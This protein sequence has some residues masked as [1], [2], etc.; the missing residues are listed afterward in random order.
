MHFSWSKTP[1]P[2]HSECFVAVLLTRNRAEFWTFFALPNFREPAIQKL[3]PFFT[4]VV[5]MFLCMFFK[6]F[7]IKVKKYVFY[8]FYSKIIVFVIYALKDVY[9]SS[10][11]H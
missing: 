2:G 8:V 6:C 1:F 4:P 11:W 5:L 3:D 7:F 10:S 9:S